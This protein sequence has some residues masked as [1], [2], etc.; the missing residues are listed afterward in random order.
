[1]TLAADGAKREEEKKKELFDR[2]P[3]PQ[4]DWGFTRMDADE[5][6]KR[7]GKQKKMYPRITP[8]TRIKDKQKRRIRER[9]L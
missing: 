2:R 5:M 6:K 7:K 4:P 3:R 9:I 1:V 8:I